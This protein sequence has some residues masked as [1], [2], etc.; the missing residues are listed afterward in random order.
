MGAPQGPQ[1][2][3]K[4]QSMTDRDRHNRQGRIIALVIA[5]TGLAWIAA[6]LAGEALVPGYYARLAESLRTTFDLDD[7]G[8]AFFVI[9]D[10]AD[11]DHSGIGRRILEDFATSE[12]DLERVLEVVKEM[13][14]VMALQNADTWR[15]M[16]DAA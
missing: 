5:G 15:A 6:M 1:G 7:K 13:S 12:K 14:S 11:E 4:G 3:G 8:V 9:H 16:Q 2:Q 10:V